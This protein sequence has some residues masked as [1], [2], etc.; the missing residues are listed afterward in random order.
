MHFIWWLVVGGLAGFLA[1]KFM[2]GRGFGVVGNVIVGIIGAVVG[3][4]VL[5]LL[6]FRSEGSLLATLITSFIGAVLFLFGMGFV[7]RSE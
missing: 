7:R 5:G 4:F 1:G 6:G 3:G 2:D